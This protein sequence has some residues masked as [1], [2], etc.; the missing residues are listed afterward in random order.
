LND[1]SQYSW[2]TA[3]IWQTSRNLARFRQYSWTLALLGQ[4]PAESSWDPAVLAQIPVG[5]SWNLANL[6]RIWPDF[7]E[8]GR[9][10]AMATGCCR[11][12]FFAVANFFVQ[13]KLW[14]IFL[15]NDFIEIFYDVNYF[16]SKQTEHKN[17][18]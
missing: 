3:K 11:I 5:C 8:F 10:P 18:T 2:S 6:A 12:P 7:G 9:N 1:S 17:H 14:K 15:N 4:I 13:V 16:T